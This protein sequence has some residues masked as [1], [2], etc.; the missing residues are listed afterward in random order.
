MRTILAGFISLLLAG[1]TTVRTP[2]Y[3]LKI[4]VIDKRAVESEANRILQEIQP[5][6]TNINPDTNQDIKDAVA[7]RD[8]LRNEFNH[9][10]T[11]P[12]PMRP[13][14][15]RGTDRPPEL[16]EQEKER[17]TVLTKELDAANAPLQEYDQ[18]MR[19]RS[20]TASR[21]VLEAVK[22]ISCKRY[23][24]VYDSTWLRIGDDHEVVYSTQIVKPPNITD[25]V[26]QELNANKALYFPFHN[27]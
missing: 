9:L 7:K 4:A 15:Y 27:E 24:A 12:F 20:A 8:G 10:Q 5:L 3:P 11:P 6:P 19:Q 21:A 17:I 23:D 14:F 18:V 22:H 16:T 1:C 25:Q 2:S 26:A 13:P